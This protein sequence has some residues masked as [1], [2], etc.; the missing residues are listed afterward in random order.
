MQKFKKG[1]T[2]QRTKG[3]WETVK[4]GDICTVVSADWN[5]L[6]L[7]GHSGTYD[8]EY[9][10]KVVL[11]PKEQK[12]VTIDVCHRLVAYDCE[13]ANL[14]ALQD[15]LREDFSRQLAQ[16]EGTIDTLTTEM[17]TLKSE[18]NVE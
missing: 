5:G 17:N 12:K 10:V 13:I 6:T 7:L 16:L 3:Q 2:V 8:D 18:Y 4:A 15:N 11:A 14:Q 1:D 9:F